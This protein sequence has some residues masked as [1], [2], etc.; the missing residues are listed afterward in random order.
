MKTPKPKAGDAWINDLRRSPTVS[1]V[2]VML[3]NPEIVNDRSGWRTQGI[4]LEDREKGTY[5]IFEAWMDDN[6]L[7]KWY[8]NPDRFKELVRRW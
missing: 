4:D 7:A 2:L 1:V 5:R 3:I 8:E 6:T